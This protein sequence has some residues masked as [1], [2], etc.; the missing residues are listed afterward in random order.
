MNLSCD[1]IMEVKILFV[2]KEE[3][4]E[5]YDFLLTGLP[6]IGLPAIIA[7]RHI[8]HT[9]NMK[10]VGYGSIQP[11]LLL[12]RYENKKVTPLIQVYEKDNLLVVLPEIPM[13][14]YLLRPLAEFIWNI[15]EKKNV[16]Y[17][18]FLGSLP[19]R[20]R[21]KKLSPEEL[22]MVVASVNMGDI[23]KKKIPDAKE[24]HTGVLFG[25]FAYLLWRAAEKNKSAALILSETFA[26]PLIAGD[27]TS[28]IRLVNAVSSITGIPISIEELKKKQ[29]ELR[30][31]LRS[32][33]QLVSQ[34]KPR[35]E[36]YELYT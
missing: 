9:L 27:V 28:A 5:S 34:A 14:A 17:S 2:E 15:I 22:L 10:Y 24:F 29:E 35:E 23:I 13:Q 11:P 36:T 26:R 25:P 8:V 7:L 4:K 31:A 1:D 16:K 33:E 3:M 6:E 30:I 19:S 21:E 32:L 12:V 20:D 18:I